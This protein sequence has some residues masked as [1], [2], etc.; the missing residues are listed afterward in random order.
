MTPVKWIFLWAIAFVFAAVFFG[1]N[2]APYLSGTLCGAV[3]VAVLYE[4]DRGRG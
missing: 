1:F 2:P 3:L 4:M